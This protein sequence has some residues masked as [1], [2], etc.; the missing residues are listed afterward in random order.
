MCYTFP[1]RALFSP[2][3]SATESGANAVECNYILFIL[4]YNTNFNNNRVQIK[5][6]SND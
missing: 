6:T 5:K 1:L 3:P 4:Y 2:F